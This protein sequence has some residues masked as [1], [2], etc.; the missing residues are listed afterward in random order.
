MPYFGGLRKVATLLGAILASKLCV[1]IT[2]DEAEAR[3]AEFTF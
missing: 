1:R 2:L 3:V